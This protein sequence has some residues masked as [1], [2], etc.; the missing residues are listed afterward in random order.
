MVQNNA[1][2]K[3]ETSAY[4]GYDEYEVIDDGTRDHDD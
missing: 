2:F 3:G 1:M 4:V